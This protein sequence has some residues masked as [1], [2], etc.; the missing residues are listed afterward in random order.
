LTI[1]ELQ[2]GKTRLLGQADGETSINKRCLSARIATVLDEKGDLLACY[3]KGKNIWD[4][5]TEVMVYV[6]KI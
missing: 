5:Q 2:E 3:W 6:T 4:K 1:E